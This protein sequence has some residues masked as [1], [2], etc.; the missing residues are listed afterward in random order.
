VSDEPLIATGSQTVGPFF[1]FGLTPAPNGRMVDRFP[2]GGEAIRL[3]ISVLDGDGA[4]VGDAM[5]ELWQA[6]V[7][8]RL[9]TS[10][11]GSCEFETVRPAA[12]RTDRAAHINLC[13]FARGLLR[14]VFTR[15]YFDGDPALSF[16]PVMALVPEDRRSTLVATPVPNAERVWGFEVRL[17]GAGETVFFDA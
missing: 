15:I 10:A 2:A 1:H 13:L 6:G 17:Q 5:I 3:R 11:D 8:G 9:P 4:P 7:F 16:D 14:H 12:E